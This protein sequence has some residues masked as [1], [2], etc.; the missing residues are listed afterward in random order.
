MQTS[1]PAQTVP[2]SARQSHA[3]NRF[4][5]LALLLA[6]IAMM[7]TTLV[8]VI[9]AAPRITPDEIQSELSV[10]RGRLAEMLARARDN[11]DRLRSA[12]IRDASASLYMVGA[13]GDDDS[14]WR[15]IGTA[16]VAYNAVPSTLGSCEIGTL[17]VCS[18]ASEPTDE[19]DWLAT[20]AHVADSVERA[21]RDGL[22]VVVRAPGA[23]PH[24]LPILSARI[25]PGWAFADQVTRRPLPQ[26]AE[27]GSIRGV[28]LVPFADVALLGVAAGSAAPALPIASAEVLEQLSAG[29][30]LIIL[31]FPSES[32]AGPR[33]NHPPQAGVGTLAATTSVFQRPPATSADALLLHHNIQMGGGSSGSPVLNAD[34]Q[35]VGVHS[36][37]NV[38]FIDGPRIPLATGYAQRI[39]LV[40]ELL[41]PPDRDFHDAR[42]VQWRSELRSVA[43]APA[44]LIRAFDQF[45]SRRMSVD[46][47]ETAVAP[48]L[49]DEL[50]EQGQAAELGSSHDEVHW[51]IDVRDDA[52]YAL[53]ARSV[54][55][56]ADLRIQLETGG[57]VIHSMHLSSVLP[58]ATWQSHAAGTLT[59]RVVANDGTAL[60]AD[61]VL[62]RMVRVEPAECSAY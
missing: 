24:D 35:V 20:N 46:C 44:K 56:G 17:S 4:R 62:L 48:M 22:R 23:I 47:G 29:D 32:M 40:S 42:M 31:G 39:D 59:V 60:P 52:F 11:K 21:R 41:S 19:L 13:V 2:P 33:D 37:G 14:G 25:H 57:A 38:I 54:L 12:V 61:S 15:Q 50:A 58:I 5:S 16:W 30:P 43:A 55:P 7:A 49:I 53:F 3:P 18:E 26:V 45:V 8:S 28:Q 6:T 1:S 10:H 36:A 34:G 27:D 51:T 9:G